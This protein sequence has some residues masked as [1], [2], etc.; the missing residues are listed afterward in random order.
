MRLRHLR[1]ERLNDLFAN[2]RAS[3]RRDSRA[4]RQPAREVRRVIEATI[5]LKTLCRAPSSFLRRSLLEL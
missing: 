4:S 1:R 2:A 5:P 3:T